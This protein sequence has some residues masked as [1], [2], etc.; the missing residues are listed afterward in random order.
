MAP[1]SRLPLAVHARTPNPRRHHRVQPRKHLLHHI[2]QPSRHP[3]S[4]Q[5]RAWRHGELHLCL[6]CSTCVG[7]SSTSSSSSTLA[8]A[9]THSRTYAHTT[10]TYTYTYSAYMSA[11]AREHTQSVTLMTRQASTANHPRSHT[12]GLMTK[13]PEGMFQH[14]CSTLTNAPAARPIKMGADK[15]TPATSRP[16]PPAPYK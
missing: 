9:R 1:E 16:T 2:Q 8:T 6:A 13:F 15:Q 14:T 4:L 5:A 7:R 3:Q 10:H 12:K 11:R